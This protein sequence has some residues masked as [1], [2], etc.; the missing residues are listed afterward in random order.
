MFLQDLVCIQFFYE[1]SWLGS[2]VKQI[3]IIVCLALSFIYLLV[4]EWGDVWCSS[5][6]EW[7]AGVK[8]QGHANLVQ[9]KHRQTT[10]SLNIVQEKKNIPSQKF[11]PNRP[12]PDMIVTPTREH[13]RLL[14]NTVNFLSKYYNKKSSWHQAIT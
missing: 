9:T 7:V 13:Q 1:D 4:S 14:W 6:V 5:Y 12:S 2:N 8:H 11:N 3:M 10:P